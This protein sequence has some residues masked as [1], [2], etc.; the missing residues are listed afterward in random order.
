M[1]IKEYRMTRLVMNRV[2]GR[3]KKI[4]CRECGETIELDE[5]VVSKRSG[6]RNGIRIYHKKCAMKVNIL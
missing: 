1:V 4:K 2:A 3:G 5:E 6:F